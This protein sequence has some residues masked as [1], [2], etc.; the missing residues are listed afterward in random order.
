MAS[1][2]LGLRAALFQVGASE[3]VVYA[4]PGGVPVRC[5]AVRSGDAALLVSDQGGNP[6]R[7]VTFEI[8]RSLL[9][10]KPVRKATIT[11][12]GNEVWI[13]TNTTDQDTVDSWLVNVERGA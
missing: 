9:P 5:R 7:G 4:A 1:P 6:L 10:V 12:D 8:P 3:A 2:L 11:A 13:V